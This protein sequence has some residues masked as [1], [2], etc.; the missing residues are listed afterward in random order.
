MPPGL[1]LAGCPKWLRPQAVCCCHGKDAR[2]GRVQGS[3][4]CWL[5]S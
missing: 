2:V 1:A 4:D 5:S 3:G